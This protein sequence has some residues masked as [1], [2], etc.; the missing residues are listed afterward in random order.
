[1]RE[2]SVAEQRYEA[3]RAVI[4]DD[5]TIKHVAARGTRKMPAR[6]GIPP[7]LRP[8]RALRRHQGPYRSAALHEIAA[9][10]LDLPS[11]LLAAS[12]DAAPEV[13]RFDAELGGEIARSGA[14]ALRVRSKLTD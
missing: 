2:M 1:M 6:A 7:A 4:A 5:D 8:A 11:E 14:P 9:L 10:P 12:S 13:A 3:V